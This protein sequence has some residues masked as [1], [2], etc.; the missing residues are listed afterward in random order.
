MKAGRLRA[1]AT[2]GSKRS[3][4]APDLPTVAE[5]GYPGFD[6]SSW[7]ALMLPAATPNPIVERIRAEGILALQQADVQNAITRQGL[8]PESST[9][10]ELAT[11][12]KNES[13]MWA[14]VIKEAGIRAQ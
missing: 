10:A 4:V 3:K 2:T 14:A 13:L 8:E 9:P 7:Y 12:I 11:R 5:L 6:V 1:V